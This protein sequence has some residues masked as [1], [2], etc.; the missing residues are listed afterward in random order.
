MSRPKQY[1]I[2]A[3]IRECADLRGNEKPLLIEICIMYTLGTRKICDAKNQHFVEVLGIDK[4]TISRILQR[5]VTK[6]F[7]E[8]DPGKERGN[9]RVIWPTEHALALYLSPAEIDALR[10]ENHANLPIDDLRVAIDEY[11]AILSTICRYPIDEMPIGVSTN[12]RLTIDESSFALLLVK[13]FTFNLIESGRKKS[14]ALIDLKKNGGENQKKM[15]AS[16]I[17]EVPEHNETGV[18]TVLPFVPDLTATD[19]EFGR[20]QAVPRDV[21]MVDAYLRRIGHGFAGYGQDFYDFYQARDW[22][23]GFHQARCTNW[24][25]LLGRWKFEDVKKQLA[26]KG[27]HMQQRLDLVKH[28]L[29]TTEFDDNGKI[30]R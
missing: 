21:E 5:L 12:R 3:R 29:E 28:V 14:P 26:Q 16:Q 9:S 24:K 13:E 15:G 6:G 17:F 20:W 11:R 7:V 23:V 19:D 1:P 27:G 10:G 2:A 4:D 25:S 18:V 30:K 8:V 22:R